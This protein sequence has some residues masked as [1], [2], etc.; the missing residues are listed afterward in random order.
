MYMWVC[1][2]VR[3]FLT[4]FDVFPVKHGRNVSW[5]KYV[6]QNM[7]SP[8]VAS[9]AR[10][11]DATAWAVGNDLRKWGFNSNVSRFKMTKAD[12]SWGIQKQKGIAQ[13]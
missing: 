4:L 1:V 13:Q 5:E 3:D 11:Q 12:S 7:E 10:L 8:Q 9:Q 2:C 6:D